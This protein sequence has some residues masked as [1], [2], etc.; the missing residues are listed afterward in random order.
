MW[1]CCSGD[2]RYVTSMTDALEIRYHP[3][4]LANGYL[5]VRNRMA[6]LL[7]WMGFHMPSKRS[8]LASMDISA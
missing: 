4:I 7:W 3:M 2:V 1:Q 5:I 8:S 6:L